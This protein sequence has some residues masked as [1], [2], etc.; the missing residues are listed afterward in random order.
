MDVTSTIFGKANTD[1]TDMQESE[2][3]NSE[4]LSSINVALN[5]QN[6]GDK[7]TTGYATSSDMIG[8]WAFHNESSKTSIYTEDLINNEDIDRSDE[9]AQVNFQLT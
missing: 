7:E 4:I 1:I 3:Y 6:F 5:S 8:V 9:E 2:E